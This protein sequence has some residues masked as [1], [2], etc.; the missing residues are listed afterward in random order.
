M[1]IERHPRMIIS[2]EG[3]E[4][5]GKTHFA[6]SA[7]R[8]ILYLD[9]DYGVEGVSTDPTL[10]RR[11]YN[12]LPGML[13][14]AEMQQHVAREIERFRS[15]FYDGLGKFRSLVV[16]TMSAAWAGQRMKNDDKYAVH[17]EEF[18]SM[19][20]AAYA[21]PH[22]NVIL[23]HHLRQ[24]WARNQAGKAYKA[25]TWS[26]DGMDGIANAVQMAIKQRYVALL[27]AA[28]PGR[29]ELDVLKCRDNIGLV[30]QTYVGLDFVTLCTMAAPAIDWS[31]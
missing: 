3:M 26:R 20:R 4:G 31:K 1:G 23:I 13:G 30:G 5:S 21:S 18:K 22:T 8:P 11:S 10:D 15:D 25:Q 29:F 7:P 2:T 12:L 19:I 24:D 27:S 14:E 28:I 17:E 16:D 9:F 6:L